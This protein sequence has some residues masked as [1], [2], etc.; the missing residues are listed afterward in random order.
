MKLHIVIILLVNRIPMTVNQ[1][2]DIPLHQVNLDFIEAKY[3]RLMLELPSLIDDAKEVIVEDTATRNMMGYTI[4][5]SYFLG[6]TLEILGFTLMLRRSLQD[7]AASLASRR[8]YYGYVWYTGWYGAGDA[9]PWF[10]PDIFTTGGDPHIAC[11]GA[12][13]R[14]LLEEFHLGTNIQSFSVRSFAEKVIT[15]ERLQRDFNERLGCI[16]V[17]V[18]R[19]YK[20]ADQVS[21]SFQSM[22]R[23]LQ[24]HEDLQT[25][26][27]PNPQ[28]LSVLDQELDN[29][30]E[31]IVSITEE[32]LHKFYT[33]H[34]IQ[35]SYIQAYIQVSNRKAN[36]NFALLVC[37]FV[38]LMGMVGGV[39][40]AVAAVE[41]SD[42]GH[43]EEGDLLGDLVRWLLGAGVHSRHVKLLGAA[44]LVLAPLLWGYSYS[45]FLL[46]LETTDPGCGPA[47]RE[48]VYSRSVGHTHYG[49]AHVQVHALK[50]YSVAG[51]LD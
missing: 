5:F 21:A 20:E 38:N 29:V 17:H 8:E 15:V 19:D 27:H 34:S 45:S 7:T 49:L 35:L 1:K 25:H 51:F 10:F 28:D 40:L 33:N 22:L 39:I 36:K 30:W 9:S 42:L 44:A 3:H 47:D 6:S 32:V 46:F 50:R 18:N 12:D 4:A 48:A 41:A 43:A 14:Q 23:L 24:L 31:E 13:Y 26:A 2:K 11:S 37:G 16:L